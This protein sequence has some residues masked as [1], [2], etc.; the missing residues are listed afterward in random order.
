ME[1]DCP[2]WVTMQLA[3]IPRRSLR[4]ASSSARLNQYLAEGIGRSH[5]NTLLGRF[6]C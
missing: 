4:P 1:V 2:P 6:E 5:S 3:W